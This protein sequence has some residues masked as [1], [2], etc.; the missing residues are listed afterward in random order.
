MF[1]S[2]GFTHGFPLHFQGIRESSHIKN[3]LSAVQKPTVVDAKIAKELAAD[4]LAGPFDSP[5]ISPFVVSPLG[6]VP[7]KS[8]GEFWLIHHL[9]FPKGASV[10]DRICHENSTV[11]YATIGDAIRCIKL[12]GQG[13]YLAKTD[14]QNAFRIIPIQSDDYGLL[15]THWQGSVKLNWICLLICALMLASL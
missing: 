7:K 9:S 10:N 12:A 13:S 14:I 5:P 8:P 4:R 1:L 2:D 3:L 15:G 6:V 11:C